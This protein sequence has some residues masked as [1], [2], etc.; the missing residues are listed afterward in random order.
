MIVYREFFNLS[1][2]GEDMD[3]NMVSPFWLM[4]YMI[5]DQIVFSWTVSSYR[6]TVVISI[7]CHMLLLLLFS[8]LSKICKVFFA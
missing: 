7:C 1:I 4:A 5:V 8:V 3:T 2:Y 6:Y